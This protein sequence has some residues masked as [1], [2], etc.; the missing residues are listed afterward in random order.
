MNLK[1]LSGGHLIK[2]KSLTDKIKHSISGKMVDEPLHNDDNIKS[3][4]CELEICGTNFFI[5]PSRLT[6]PEKFL[7]CPVPEIF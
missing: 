2:E 7:N 5:V 4:W 6:R 1:N 3:Q